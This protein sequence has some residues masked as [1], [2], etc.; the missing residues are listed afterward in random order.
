VAKFDYDE[1]KEVAEDL[2]EDFGMICVLRKRG[3]KSGPAYDPTYAAS[4][5]TEVTAVDFYNKLY[6]RDNGSVDVTEK[7]FILSPPASVIP[8]EGDSIASNMLI[9]NIDSNTVFHVIN[10]VEPFAPGGTV[11]YWDLVCSN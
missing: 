4:S 2:L 9:A 7:R 3:V 8:E 5:D 11:L 6:N 1:M 10:R